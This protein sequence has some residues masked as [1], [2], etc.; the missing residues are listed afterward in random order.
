M[1]RFLLLSSLLK[2]SNVLI[3]DYDIFLLIL[4]NFTSFLII[5]R[6]CFIN[7]ISFLSKDSSEFLTFNTD[8]FLNRNGNEDEK[9]NF[10]L[11]NS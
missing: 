5:S 10:R 8:A 2:N 3:K 4:T 6:E 9:K 1:I 11:C 7:R